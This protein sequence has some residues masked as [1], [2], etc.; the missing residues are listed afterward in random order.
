FEVAAELGGDG[1]HAKGAHAIPNPVTGP[2]T[3]SVICPSGHRSPTPR[4]W[5]SSP[6][7]APAAGPAG[8]GGAPGS[9]A[10][11]IA[12]PGKHVSQSPA[13]TPY[14]RGTAA[15]SSTARQPLASASMPS[16]PAI[17]AM[18]TSLAAAGR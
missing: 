9:S 16:V 14:G 17:P 5:V 7:S 3:A 8:G 11:R 18:D 10:V 2:V 6:H 15:T 12:K 1:G 13:D 4:P